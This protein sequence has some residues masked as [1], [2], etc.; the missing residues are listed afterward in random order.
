MLSA[1]ASGA[2]C[3]TEIADELNLVG[4]NHRGS[5]VREGAKLLVATAPGGGF[6]R[7]GVL[8]HG[9]DH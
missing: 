5:R 3:R 1:E 8:F 4:Q 7:R 2:F 6:L 9:F